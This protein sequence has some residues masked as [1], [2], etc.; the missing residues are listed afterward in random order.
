MLEQPVVRER[1]VGMVTHYWN[2]LGVAGVHLT[3]PIDVGDHIHIMGHTTDFEQDVGSIE[4]DHHSV[5]HANS[6]DDIGIRLA[7][8]AREHDTVYKCSCDDIGADENVL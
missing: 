3:E 7:A 6:G 1:P 5:N 8:H 4:I 2:H